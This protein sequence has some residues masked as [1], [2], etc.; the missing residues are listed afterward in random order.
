[1][2]RKEAA[3]R[4][5]EEKERA[6]R[7]EKKRMKKHQKELEL[8]AERRAEM[9]KDN[10][11][12]LAIRLSELEDNMACRV[13]SVIGPLRELVRLGKKKVTYASGGSSKEPEDEV[14]DTSVTQ[15]LSAKAGRLC[16]LEKRKRGPKPVFENSL[17]MEAPPKQTPKRGAL[18][19]VLLTTRM[20]RSKAMVKNPGSVKRISL[21]KTPLSNRVKNTQT[22]RKATPRKSPALA[23]TPATKGALQRLRFRNDVMEELK[24]CDATELQRICKEEGVLYDGKVGAIFAIADSRT[25]EKFE[26]DIAETNEVIDVEVRK[27]INDALMSGDLPKCFLNRTRKKV[28]I[29][30]VK[31]S[32]VVDITH[33][34][35]EFASR[36]VLVCTCADLPFPRSEG[37]VRFRLS[38]IEGLHPLLRNA[39]NV[40][41]VVRDDR[42]ELLHEELRNGFSQWRNWRGDLSRIA[43]EELHK[44]MGSCALDK[45]QLTTAHVR[46]LKLK[47][48]GLVLTPLDRNPRETLVL[49]PSL[50][51]EAMMVT[52]VRS[53][54]YK[55]IE[56][57]SKEVLREIREDVAIRGLTKFARWDKDGD[58]GSAYVIPK[59]KDVSRYRPICPTFME[60]MV[61]T[62]R[63]VSKGMNHLLK[64]LP[65]R[66]HFNLT[67]VSGLASR[68]REV[69]R[70]ILRLDA[71]DEVLTVSFDIKEMFSGLPHKDIMAAVDWLLDF[72]RGKGRVSV[73]VNTRGRGSSF[74]RTTGA[75]HWRSLDFTQMREFVLLEL[76]H[77]YTFATGVLLQQVVAMGYLWGRLQ[78]HHW[79]VFCAH[80][81]NTVL[82]G[83]STRTLAWYTVLGWLMM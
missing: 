62:G 6:E 26:L 57:P 56:T 82:C 46:D 15:E 41:R 66:W 1:M 28:R 17:P 18:K 61:W 19:P 39:K 73:R 3:E 9:K 4:E 79:P 13:E 27:V 80:T 2:E 14:S 44:C 71:G 8:E 49:C 20:T 51:F 22:P 33:N 54:G 24:D 32:A 5:A 12:Q 55:I 50:Y 11:I 68:V 75:D 63:A 60:A 7:K 35:R 47:L 36:N 29:V 16:I 34:Q 48:Q 37:H 25:R 10:E 69:N 40:P 45:G 70:R 77:T 74:G 65:R 38:E 52:F 67:S 53:L 76:Q 58:F 64:T 31:N 83:A 21:V 81:L 23:I 43:R 72:H 78:V 42:I 59:Q 30:W